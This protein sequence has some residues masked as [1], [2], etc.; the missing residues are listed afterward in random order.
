ML[1]VTSAG[2]AEESYSGESP[3]ACTMDDILTPFRA[4]AKYV[5]MTYLDPLVFYRAAEADEET[6]NQF[7]KVFSGKLQE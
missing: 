6:I 5:D 7:C 3:L 4:C 1:V 2:A